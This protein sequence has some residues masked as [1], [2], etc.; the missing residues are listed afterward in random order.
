M[1]IYKIGFTILE[2]EI[3]KFLSLR[4][5]EKFTQRD[6]A[7]FLYVSPT[8]VSKSIRVLESKN[9]VVVEK[10]K[11]LNLVSF[12]VNNKSM[13]DFKRVEN[14]NNIY[15]SGLKSFFEENFFG[16]TVIVFGSFSRGED[17]K[18]SDIDIAVIG[19][20][21]KNLDLKQF[22]S[23]LFRK[24]N[25]NFYKSFKDIDLYLK[26]NILNGIILFGSVDCK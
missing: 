16:C 5:G 11:N 6:L 21:K 1:D 13:I 17:V 25:V 26:N 10:F 12:N 23:K 24:I 2:F 14:L 20:K 7:K 15:V 4:A 19:C 3:L 22:E 18:N 9:F 8:A